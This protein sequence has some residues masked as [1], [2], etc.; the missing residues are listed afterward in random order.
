MTNRFGR[1]WTSWCRTC[2]AYRRM[3]AADRSLCSVCGKP[4]AADP[5][6]EEEADGRA[7]AAIIRFFRKVLGKD[8]QQGEGE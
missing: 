6:A 1:N 8:E 5:R 3:S 7:H 2:D 4:F